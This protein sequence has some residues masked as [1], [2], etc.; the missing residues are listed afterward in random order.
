MSLYDFSSNSQIDLLLEYCISIEKQNVKDENIK[1][2][3][4]KIFYDF[5]AKNKAYT[6]FKLLVGN[7]LQEHY[8]NLNT[9]CG[10][11]ERRDS[12][13]RCL[14]NFYSKYKD[15][16]NN[17]KYC[18]L[19]RFLIDLLSEL[20]FDNDIKCICIFEE[21]ESFLNDTTDNNI[22]VFDENEQ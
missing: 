16:N 3:L 4:I 17:K 2:K 11:E 15:G 19:F 20:D 21:I 14:Y 7:A 1:T 18:D 10:V 5:F 13:V 8:H 12:V 22:Y 9:N 6:D